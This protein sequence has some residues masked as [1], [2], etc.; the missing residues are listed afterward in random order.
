M[1]SRHL[2][3]LDASSERR[4]FLVF[5]LLETFGVPAHQGSDVAAKKYTA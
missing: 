1:P 5:L 4:A 2:P 3:S